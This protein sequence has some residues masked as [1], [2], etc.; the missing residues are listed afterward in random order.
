MERWR[1]I[2]GLKSRQRLGHHENGFQPGFRPEQPAA[3][4]LVA[5][6]LTSAAF[7]AAPL[8]RRCF[9]CLRDRRY[10]AAYAAVFTRR[11]IEAGCEARPGQ[12]KP[13]SARASRVLLRLYDRRGPVSP[14]LQHIPERLGVRELQPQSHARALRVRV[15]TPGCKR[16]AT[17]P[18]RT[19]VP[20]ALG[21]VSA[22][23]D[24]ALLLQFLLSV[25]CGQAT[26]GALWALAHCHSFSRLRAVR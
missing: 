14:D 10:D 24:R 25:A 1:A 21:D 9:R 6:T 15:D 11:R 20:A 4:A 19:V 12:Y 22:C 13:E 18:R 26:G 5:R 3:D 8:V 7:R 17:H 2:V 23:G 16:H